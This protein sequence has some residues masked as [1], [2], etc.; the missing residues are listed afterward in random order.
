[1][2][3]IYCDSSY[4]PVFGELGW[5]GLGHDLCISDNANTSPSNSYLGSTYEL[6]QGQQRTFITGTGDFTVTDYEVFGL[7]Q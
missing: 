3:G 2:S 6:P 7:R 5:F 1:M 4:G